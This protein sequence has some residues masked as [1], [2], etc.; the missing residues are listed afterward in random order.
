MTHRDPRGG[1]STAPAPLSTPLVGPQ[2]AK[3]ARQRL[4]HS[5]LRAGIAS[6]HQMLA[7]LE[8]QL[9]A[10]CEVE[11]SRG[12]ARAVRMDDRASWDRAT[13]DRYLAAASRLEPH[14]GPRMRRLWLEVEQL[15]RLA[16][17]PSAA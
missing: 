10:A 16:K 17:L 15:E 1:L 3:R 6:R 8:A 14:Y 11:A 12:R 2:H 7:D 9:A 13:W 4:D 5:R